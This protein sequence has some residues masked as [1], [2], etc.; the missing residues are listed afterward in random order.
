MTK[1]QIVSGIK[2]SVDHECSDDSFLLI[3][4]F[5]GQRFVEIVVYGW[6]GLHLLYKKWVI[7]RRFRIIYENKS[8]NT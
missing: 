3:G 7:E 8:I 1:E 4:D 6:F 2:W 5:N